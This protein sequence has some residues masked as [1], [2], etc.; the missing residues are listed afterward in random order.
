MRLMQWNANSITLRKYELEHF[1]Q[2][3]RIDVAAICETKLS[4]RRKFTVQ[5][6]SIYR[7]DRNHHGGGVLLLIR[8]EI[9]HDSIHLTG[10]S[11]MELVSVIVHSP[12]QKRF[13][14]VAGYNPPNNTLSSNDLDPIF[15]KN[16]PT[17]VLG[18][19]NSK[20]I[21]WN[22]THSDR[23]G[24]FLME[25]CTDRYVSIH[26]PI[27]PTHFPARGQPSVLDISLVRGCSL[28]TPQSLP[29]LS[30]D[31]NPVGL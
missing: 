6:Y 31:H 10:T 9:Q 7:T 5:G 8:N 21:A 13:L 26:A 24:N 2:A 4:P 1:L 14:I 23:N 28:S 18:D 3:N 30:S 27:Y 19:F 29:I 20:H 15:E 12:Q 17:I 25:Y 16:L 11:E 22:C